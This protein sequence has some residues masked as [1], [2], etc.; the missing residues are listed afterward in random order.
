M[1]TEAVLL[2]P[3]TL[4]LA[5]TG[6]TGAPWVDSA[7]V[8]TAVVDPA[9]PAA[10]TRPVGYWPL[11]EADSVVVELANDREGLLFG[12]TDVDG[13]AGPAQAFDGGAWAE[14]G[15]HLDKMTTGDDAR[16]SLGLWLY[17]QGGPGVLWS[18]TS[19]PS[20]CAAADTAAE[21]LARL[22]PQGRVV[23][24]LFGDAGGL[25]RVRSVDPVP[26]EA[27]SHLVIVHDIAAP[28]AE[29]RVQLYLDGLPWAADLLRARGGRFPI[30]NTDAPL[31]LGAQLDVDGVPCATPGFEGALDEA[32]VFNVALGPDQVEAV[33]ARSAW[34]A[35][36]LAEDDPQELVFVLD[37]SCSMAGS[38]MIGTDIALEAAAV[39]LVQDPGPADMVGAV[40]FSEQALVWTEPFVIADDPDA[41][42]AQ[43]STFGSLSTL[44]ATNHAVALQTARELLA[45]RADQGYLQG[46]V[47]ITDGNPTVGTQA[48]RLAEVDAVRAAGIHVW[49]ISF[50]SSIN[51]SLM[52]TYTQGYGT[53]ESTPSASGLFYIVTNILESTP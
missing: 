14:L 5:A 25:L 15:T 21:F 6:D 4:A 1:T 33:H 30:P 46:I 29:E 31:A 19:H 42:L 22:D 35:S 9:P 51:H 43:W 24:E 52:G 27:W 18:K 10:Y 44:G 38:G 11:D 37:L 3:L 47:L 40:L 32:A 23:V 28:S 16:F 8:D 20:V 17:P 7:L 41:L 12:T 39:L 49:T 26:P 36:L 53:Y 13:P 2:F 48:E 34:G 45:E 50:G